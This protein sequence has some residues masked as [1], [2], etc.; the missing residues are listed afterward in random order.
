MK[1]HYLFFMI[2]PLLLNLAGRA[3]TGYLH[4]SG[5]KIVNGNGEEVI[6]RGMGLG[7]W[8]L[9]EGY[10][11]ETS[12]FAGPQHEIKKKI[13]E[14]VG[15]EAT[16]EF[17]DAWLDNYCTK[18]DVDSM[19]AWGFN[20]IR[21]PMHYNLF[22]LPIEEEMTSGSD[23]WLDKGFTIVDNLLD[24]CEANHIYLILDLH[25]APG[26]QGKDKN[27]SDYDPSK[28]SLWESAENR[29]KTIALWKK[30]AER[31][32]NEP[33][34]GSYDLINE[35]NWDIDNTGNPNGCSCNQNTALWNLYK[36]I[37]KAVRTVDN[38]HLVIIE[39]N[40]WGNRYNGLTNIT[41]FDNNLVMSFHKYWSYNDVGSIQEILNLRNTH[42]VPIWLGESGE[43]SNPWFTSAIKLVEN[44][45]IGWAWW[46]YKKIGS[47]TG[48]VTIPKTE[49]W[50]KLL[51]YW[52]G[53]GPKPSNYE[54]SNWLLEQAEQMKLENCTIHRD[55]LDA[56]FRQIKS[57]EPVPF[58]KHTMPGTIFMTDYDLGGNGYAYFDTDTADFHVSTNTYTAWNSGYVYRND[59]VD[60]EACT[61]VAGTNGFSIGWSNKGEWLLYT[62]EVDA[63]A[64]YSIDIR[65]AAQGSAGTLH[66]EI[67]G[68]NITQQISLPS[69]GSWSTWGTKTVQNV[70]LKKGKHQLKLFIDNAG[71]NINFLK[72]HTPIEVGS[73][74]P[75][76]INIKTN[77]TGEQIRL[78]SNVGF[79]LASL[80]PANQFELVVNNATRSISA[81]HF[82][83]ANPDILVL[84]I[85][86]ALISTDKITLSYKGNSL[87]S[88]N[89][90][91]YSPFD[92]REVQNMA[93]TYFLLPGKFEAE[94]FV[95]N[96]GFQTENCT[97]AGGGLNLGYANP[98]DYTDYDVYVD[99][100][101][102]YK[103][104]YRIACNVSGKFEMRMVEG[105]NV[106]TLHSMN[107]T[108]TGGWQSWKTLSAQATLN[109]GK[110]RLRFYAVSG[111][112][113][114]NW[115][116]VS[117][118]TGIENLNSGRN[119]LYAYYDAVENSIKV[120]NKGSLE[121]EF[122]ISCF[123]INGRCLVNQQVEFD[124]SNA[125]ISGVLLK[126]GIYLVRFKTAK[127]V[128][129]QKIRVTTT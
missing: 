120:V 72:F 45:G 121:N 18:E 61:D 88:N 118:I 38:N 35:P 8:M 9:Q 42:N 66:F 20:S 69:T 22:T 124:G 107:V 67:D 126:T 51:N 123:D 37:I 91:A 87:K 40:C 1:T 116:S 85:D 83:E 34:I 53:S 113:N 111:E 84:Q 44:N 58:K 70:V 41:S 109:Q 104:D 101:G 82:D 19:A 78:V 105:N 17:Y 115:I 74:T 29:R 117:T 81:V 99:Y 36:D 43:N 96:N 31:Y 25:G 108:S 47:V 68:E 100:N 97:D 60:I 86:G 129:T 75:D 125:I 27:I 63:T 127:D 89:Q 98:G 76:I 50:Q 128:F 59:G 77:S 80:P 92:K 39:G 95:V 119:N 54:A 71:F 33:W 65:Y 16:E 55:V 48:T 15:T 28:L 110:N 11:L 14:L 94:N 26:G 57:K 112:F 13:E 6:L 90:L 64:A 23:T 30:L 106:T 93:P 56:M 62:V 2:I 7:G 24:W 49:G 4:A 32:A 102:L 52:K 12:D 103:F 114:L 79:D 46:T 10:M 5:K 73:V 21:L 3:Q 122:E